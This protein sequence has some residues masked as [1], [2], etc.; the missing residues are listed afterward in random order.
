M[1]HTHSI[2]FK[3]IAA[4]I[5][6][7]AVVTLISTLFLYNYLNRIIQEKSDLIQQMYLTTMQQQ[8][9]KYIS[10]ATSLAILCANDST[11]SRVIGQN[12]P[13]SSQ[14]LLAQ[15]HLDSYLNACPEESYVDKLLAFNTDGGMIQAITRQFGSSSDAQSILSSPIYLHAKQET[16]SHPYTVMVMDSIQGNGKS[17]FALLC[18]IPNSDSQSGYSFIYLEFGT[19]LFS[20]VLIPY[21]EVNN[22]FLLGPD[23]S[24]LSERPEALP[25]S[26]NSQTLTAGDIRFG[27]EQ[28]NI[29]SA[30]LSDGDIT[31]YTATKVDAFN[32]DG[33]HITYTV[34]VV[35]ITGL[36]LAAILAFIV[37]TYLTR[38]IQRLNERLKRITA[39][40]FSFDSQIESTDDEIGEIGHT[41]NE[42]TMSISH[43][44]QETAEMYEERKNIEISLLQSQV[45]PHFLYNTLD[46]IRWM[47]MIQKCPGIASM[48][49]SLVNLLKNI[50]KGTQDKIPLREEMAL[51]DDYIAIQ[52]VR[53]METFTFI[54]NVPK[55]LAECRIIKLTLQPLV[56]NAIFHD[57]EPTGKCGTITLSGYEE[58]GNIVLTVEDNGVGIEPSC[59]ATLLTAQHKRDRSSLN[60]IGIANVHKRLQLTYG[61][62]YGLTVESELGH[63]TRIHVRFLKEV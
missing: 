55:E 39:N 19:D 43:L 48:V 34:I 50:A 41:V 51:L 10:D 33:A 45:N 32:Q 36:V 7:V 62:Q 17:A 21:A 15:N 31:I 12:G 46:T 16:F 1:K 11:I 27:N 53:Y 6:C 14:T 25:D 8:M 9:D 52:N 56:E 37:S 4:T 13:T 26:F 29:E 18:P 49:G 23:G 42:M 61:K 47:A 63:Y 60:G 22:V 54:N 35:F 59:L 28:W 2:K 5:S 58:D 30:S 20:D 24:F 57:I 3:L 40:D 44:L 38:P